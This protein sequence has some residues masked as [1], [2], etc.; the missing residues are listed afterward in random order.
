MLD[1]RPYEH[2][3]EVHNRN[4]PEMKKEVEMEI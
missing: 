4:M 2:S 3:K 1:F